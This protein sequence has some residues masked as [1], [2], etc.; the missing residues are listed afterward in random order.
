VDVRVWSLR[1]RHIIDRLPLQLKVQKVI[2]WPADCVLM[3]EGEILAAA[4]TPYPYLRGCNA[5]ILRF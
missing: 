1:M 3:G 2:E 4:Y 5:Y